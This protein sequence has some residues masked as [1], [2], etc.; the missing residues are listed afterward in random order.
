MLVEALKT[1]LSRYLK[2]FVLEVSNTRVFPHYK[3]E[4][5]IVRSFIETLI[6]L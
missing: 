5:A 3:E 2:I 1:K 4:R 6:N